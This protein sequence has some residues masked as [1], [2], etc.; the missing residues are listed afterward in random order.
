V[1]KVRDV[2]GAHY[3]D[4]LLPPTASNPRRMTIRP[5]VG[6]RMASM[7]HLSWIAVAVAV[8]LVIAL[9]YPLLQT[10]R[11][12]RTVQSELGRANE[13][14][15]QSEKAAKELE[16]VNANLHKELDAAPRRVQKSKKTWMRRAPITSS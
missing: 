12:L 10:T 5:F 7:R 2:I 13:Q 3:A 9:A 8:V 14:V 11:Q 16:R 1:I 15:V 6:K 4:N